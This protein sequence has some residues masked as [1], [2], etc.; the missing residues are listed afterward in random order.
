MLDHEVSEIKLAVRG[1]FQFQKRLQKDDDRGAIL[2]ARFDQ[3][4]FSHRF[5]R[6]VKILTGVIKCAAIP[7][8]LPQHLARPVADLPSISDI[9]GTLLTPFQSSLC[10]HGR[11]T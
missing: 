5:H 7:H 4:H 6:L 10:H 11:N 2:D 3:W 1:L 9:G 8:E